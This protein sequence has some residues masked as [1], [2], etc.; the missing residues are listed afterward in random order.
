M[1]SKNVE[2]L[3]AA[4]E[5]WNNRDF[6]SLVQNL[7][8]NLVYVDGPTDRR[9]TGKGG[10]RTYVQEWAKAMSDGRITKPEFIDA[11]D[12]VVAQFTGEGTNDGPW[13]GFPPTH[14]WVSF[15]FC[16][17]WK[18]DKNGRMVSGN[19][20]YDQYSILTQLGHVKPL[21]QAA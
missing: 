11:G 17:I 4:Y 8:D 15:A 19:C 14:K 20:Y 13:V 12:T 7:S 6:D 21:P 18:F 1:V 2:T 10:F 9:I 3:R 16:E 5:S